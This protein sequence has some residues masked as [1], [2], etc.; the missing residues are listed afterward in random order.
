MFSCGEKDS[1]T[2]FYYPVDSLLK[3]QVNYLTSSHATLTKRAFIDGKEETSSYVPKFD[4][5]MTAW[6][7]ELDVFAELNDINT[8][9]NV[10]KYR[11]EG[12]VKDQTSNLLI[13][14]I[15]SMEKLP[16]SYVKVYYLNSLSDVRKIEALYSQENSLL[17]TSRELLM[18]F[19][20]INNKIVLT[21]YSIQGGQKML[22]GDSVTF[23][24]QGTVTLP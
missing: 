18:E 20:N 19:Q 13:F 24:V 14:T 6:S 21:S 23:S 22:L 5:A 2:K 8:P 4:S 7:R 15:E 10:G 17:K 11:T 9:T 3:A 12:G 16:V 1:D